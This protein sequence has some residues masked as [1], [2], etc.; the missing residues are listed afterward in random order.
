VVVSCWRRRRPS[1]VCVGMFLA[2][3]DCW[4]CRP[5][6]AAVVV[7]RSGQGCFRR[8]RFLPCW[9]SVCPGVVR[10]CAAGWCVRHFLFRFGGGRLRLDETVKSLSGGPRRM[11]GAGRLEAVSARKNKRCSLVDGVGRAFELPWHMT[12][13]SAVLSVIFLY[14]VDLTR[15]CSLFIRRP[16]WNSGHGHVKHTVSRSSP[17]GP[18]VTEPSNWS[19]ISYVLGETKNW[20]YT[21]AYS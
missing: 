21:Q 17:G 5:V 7:E 2:G 12:S 13:I 6:S 3:V 9:I 20:R 11:H 1:S 15:R 14:G 8:R 16:A 4:W 10:V 19:A 18:F